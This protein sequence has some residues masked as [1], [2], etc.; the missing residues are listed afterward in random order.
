MRSGLFDIGIVGI[1]GLFRHER[2]RWLSVLGMISSLSITSYFIVV[3]SFVNGG[4][5]GD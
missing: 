5:N 4:P 1:A 3:M 2:L